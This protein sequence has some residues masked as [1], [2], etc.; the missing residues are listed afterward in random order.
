MITLKNVHV[1][2]RSRACPE[3]E[4]TSKDVTLYWKKDGQL[5][6]RSCT[7]FDLSARLKSHMV[8]CAGTAFC[9]QAA[10]SVSHS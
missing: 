4:L 1:K 9:I 8:V 7:E 5:L 2:E 3:C 10:F 6:V